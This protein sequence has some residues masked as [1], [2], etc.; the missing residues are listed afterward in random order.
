[1]DCA[2][3][4]GAIAIQ[5]L[6]SAIG[7]DHLSIQVSHGDVTSSG[8]LNFNCG[9]DYVK[10]HQ[11]PPHGMNLSPEQMSCSLDGDADR[12]VFYYSDSNRF[13]TFR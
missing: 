2:N 1:M 4:V 5:Q 10:M 6:L 8:V 12:I 3:G 9:A 7:H 11:K 13:L